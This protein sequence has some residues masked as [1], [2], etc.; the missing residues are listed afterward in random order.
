MA[1]GIQSTLD[2]SIG[3]RSL[4]NQCF[5]N[6]VVGDASR[7]EKQF[8]AGSPFPFLVLFSFFCQAENMRITPP[9]DDA[10]LRDEN[11]SSLGG[12]AGVLSP[13]RTTAVRSSSAP[14]TSRSRVLRA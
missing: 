4:V 3:L 8:H 12:N 1:V 5:P 6:A 10:H 9:L 13:G 14:D 2:A 7:S 11:K